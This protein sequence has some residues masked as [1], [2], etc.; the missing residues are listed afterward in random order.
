MFRELEEEEIDQVLVD[1][2]WEAGAPDLSRI[3]M[4]GE[5]N[6]DIL[7]SWIQPYSI[8]WVYKSRFE[9]IKLQINNFLIIFQIIDIF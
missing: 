4:D 2:Y 5:F 8:C 9:K 6:D 7:G 3:I 1:L